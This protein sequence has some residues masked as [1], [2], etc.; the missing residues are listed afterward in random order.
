MR[1]KER[2][3]LWNAIRVKME[4]REVPSASYSS[5]SSLLCGFGWVGGGE[6]DV[7]I[8]IVE[9]KLSSPS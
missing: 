9:M 5:C 8:I 6:G 3:Y 7:G 4:I 2:F 1:T